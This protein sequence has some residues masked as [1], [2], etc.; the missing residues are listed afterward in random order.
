MTFGLGVLIE[1]SEMNAH[2]GC[3]DGLLGVIQ[4]PSSFLHRQVV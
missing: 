3:G 4:L 1:V 2:K